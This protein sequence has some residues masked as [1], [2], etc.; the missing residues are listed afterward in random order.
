MYYCRRTC[1]LYHGN[2]TCMYYSHNPCTHSGHGSCTMSYEAHISWPLRRGVGWTKPP[3]AAEVVGGS[4]LA[5]C[6]QIFLL[7]PR[8]LSLAISRSLVTSWHGSPFGCRL[9]LQKE[10]LSS[11]SRSPSFSKRK[12]NFEGFPCK[13]FVVFFIGEYRVLGANTLLWKTFFLSLLTPPSPPGRRV[14][15]NS[16]FPA[17]TNWTKPKRIQPT[18]PTPLFCVKKTKQ[19]KHKIPIQTGNSFVASSN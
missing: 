9:R 1:T 5:H 7:A 8:G 16:G 2:S 6:E 12:S 15:G 3:I 19:Q 17:E 10:N 4:K 13:C 18:P 11:P 14:R